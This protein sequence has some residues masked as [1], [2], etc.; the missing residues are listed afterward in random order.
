MANFISREGV[1]DV[2]AGGRSQTPVLKVTGLTPGT[3]LKVTCNFCAHAAHRDAGEGFFY[4]LGAHGD[5]DMLAMTP[6]TGVFQ[7]DDGWQTCTL[8]TVFQVLAGTNGEVDLECLFHKGNLSGAGTI[9]NF[10][11]IAE[12]L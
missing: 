1:W 9:M 2:H 12:L 5:D 7:G 4:T 3:F 10:V 6:T 8:V 11:L